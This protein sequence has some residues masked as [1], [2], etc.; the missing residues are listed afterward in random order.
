MPVAPTYPGVYIEEVPSGVHTIAGVATSIAA[1]IDCFNRGRANRPIHLLSLADFERELGGLRIDSEGS[2]AI[3]QFFQNGG[4]EAWV[5][6]AEQAAAGP[7]GFVVA[8]AHLGDAAAAFALDIDAISP[9]TWGNN[10][11]IRIDNA[12]ATTFNLTISELN[13]TRTA[14]VRQE[15]FRNLSMD[16]ANLRFV[17]GVVNDENTGSALVRVARQSGNL[18]L[19]NGAVTIPPPVLPLA[20]NPNPGS[21][22]IA[23]DGAAPITATV[24]PRAAVNSIDDVRGI[25]EGAIRSAA[26]ANPVIAGASVTVETGDRLR[27][28][29]GIGNGT[30]NRLTFAATADPESVD[31]GLTGGGVPNVGTYQIGYTGVTVDSQ[32]AVANAA[33]ENGLRP[34]A[35]EINGN[36]VAKTGIFALE[37]VDLFNILCLPVIAGHGF[38]A[39]QADAVLAV[40]ETYCEQRRAFL[41]VDTPDG[42]R[43]PS[44]IQNWLS[45]R[46]NL[47]HRNAGL[48]YPRVHVP[49]PLD[50]FRLRSFGASGTIAGL[51]ARIDVNRGVWKAPAGTEATLTNVGELEYPMT[52]AENGTLNPLAINCLREFPIYG[53]VSWGAR[54]MVGAD[55]GNVDWRYVPVRRLALFLEESLYRGTKWA[56]FEPND[57]PLWAQIRLNVGAFMHDLFRQGAF[58]GSTPSQAYLVQCDQTTTTQSDINNGI[59][60]IIV[61]FAPLKPAEFVIIHIQQLA[62]QIQT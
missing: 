40:A 27:I 18:P 52:D 3:Q 14:V 45:T 6:R 54:T 39:G 16:P 30:L 17:D 10:L 56:V 48:Y 20:P 51:M 36:P 47:R 32:L 19:Q 11:R 21:F 57:E 23:L 26:P 58:Q 2:Y 12:S 22:N 25:V 9:G 28:V 1:F 42:F 49:D 62:G 34:T 46:G 4:T 33:G 35:A 24:P 60:N 38:N 41:V 15:V 31:F 53:R 8:T 59:V 29:P 44:A 50:E 13:A 43:L 55:N 5:I 37:D 7:N 61:G